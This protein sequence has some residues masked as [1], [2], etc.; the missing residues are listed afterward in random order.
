MGE[1][2]VKHGFITTY[3]SAIFVRRVNDFRFE[4]SMPISK[5]S[6]RPS[7]RQC[8]LA[9]CC[10]ASNDPV[11]M[12]PDGFNPTLVSSLSPACFWQYD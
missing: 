4:L 10:L 8:F 5:D 1:N 3:T 2:K 6:V 12:V 7:L 9:F 11:Y